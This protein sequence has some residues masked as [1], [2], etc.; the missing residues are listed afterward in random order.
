MMTGI[1]V[2]LS[3]GILLTGTA[4]ASAEDCPKG[5]APIVDVNGNPQCVAVD[6]TDPE[7][8]APPTTPPTPP[9]TDLPEPEEPAPPE[10]ERSPLPPLPFRPRGPR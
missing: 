2:L 7:P 10:T 9:P 5:I 8:T 1:V 6:G 3:L 4:G